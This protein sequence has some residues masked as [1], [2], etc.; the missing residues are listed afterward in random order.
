MVVFGS[1]RGARM[2]AFFYGHMFVLASA[3]SSL[4]GFM[5]IISAILSFSAAMAA[6]P[7]AMN[8][9]VYQKKIYKIYKN[10]K[11][12]VWVHPFCMLHSTVVL[13]GF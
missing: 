4:L 11:I 2:A 1:C 10:L 7:P 3:C 12:G 5:F 13:Y 8:L 9:I 6:T